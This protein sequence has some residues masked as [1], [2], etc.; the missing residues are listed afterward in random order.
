MKTKLEQHGLGMASNTN[1]HNLFMQRLRNAMAK[2]LAPRCDGHV[3][4]E[5]SVKEDDKS[6]YPHIE[7]DISVWRK[8]TYTPPETLYED[9]LLV[10]EIV[11]NNKNRQTAIVN[12]NKAFDYQPTMREAF[13]LDYAKGIWSR[14]E[15]ENGETTEKKNN[16]N[17]ILLDCH[18]N[19]I[20]QECVGQES[21]LIEM[22]EYQVDGDRFQIFNELKI[23]LTSELRSKSRYPKCIQSDYNFTD[24]RKLSRTVKPMVSIWKEA[25]L[26]IENLYWTH[27]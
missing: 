25:T 9:L 4:I 5:V 2:R 8:C 27:L 1:S 6:L 7:P 13:I 11:H 16:D 19:S 24:P 10:V 15:R 12:I 20:L 21:T 22:G 14:F 3:A 23:N 26:K 17:S 18:L